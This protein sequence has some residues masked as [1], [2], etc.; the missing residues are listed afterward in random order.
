MRLL[1][2]DR[3]GN[4][5]GK[6]PHHRYVFCKQLFAIKWNGIHRFRINFNAELN[7]S[8]LIRSGHSVTQAGYTRW[9]MAPNCNAAPKRTITCQIVL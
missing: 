9:T 4:D 1:I 2:L 6:M 7:D 3:N 5:D 8:G